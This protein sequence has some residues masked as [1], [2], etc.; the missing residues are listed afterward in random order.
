[1]RATNPLYYDV[2]ASR[3]VGFAG[4]IASTTF[5]TV[6]QSPSVAQLVEPRTSDSPASSKSWRGSNIVAGGS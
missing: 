4:V 2:G 3:A 1:M 5:I 6:V